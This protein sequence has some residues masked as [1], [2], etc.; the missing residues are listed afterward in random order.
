MVA[1]EELEALLLEDATAM[2][3]DDTATLELEALLLEDTTATELDDIAT[4][5]LEALLLDEATT[6]ELDKAPTSTILGTG[7]LSTPLPNKNDK[8]GG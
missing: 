2:E 6:L 5:E 8:C 1:A 7:A 4:L 3:L